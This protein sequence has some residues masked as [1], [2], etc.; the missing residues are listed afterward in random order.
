M[1]LK[2]CCIKKGILLMFWFRINEV[3]KCWIK[4]KLVELFLYVENEV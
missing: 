1:V 2:K 3:E 4:Y